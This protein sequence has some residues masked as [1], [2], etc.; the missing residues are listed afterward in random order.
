MKEVTGRYSLGR[1][2]GVCRQR[3]HVTVGLQNSGCRQGT[4]MLSG[5]IGKN[6]PGTAS[7]SQEPHGSPHDTG[8]TMAGKR[9]PTSNS[10]SSQMASQIYKVWRG[11][12]IFQ[13]PFLRKSLEGTHRERGRYS[14]RKQEGHSRFPG[15]GE[16]ETPGG[17]LRLLLEGLRQRGTLREKEVLR[18]NKLGMLDSLI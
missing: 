1:G 10:R 13:A 18:E 9:S 4:L 15:L 6:G 11:E 17:Q 12:R 8:T 2:A 3:E 5:H 14:D 16:R 7:G